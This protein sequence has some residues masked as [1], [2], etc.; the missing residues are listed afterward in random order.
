MPA[1]AQT[2]TPADAETQATDAPEAKSSSKKVCKNFKVTG[3]RLARQRVCATQA[4]WDRNAREAEEL[5]G[6]LTERP[7]R[8]PVEGAASS[9]F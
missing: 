6:T 4:E 1:V 9:P 7:A 2:S 8:G 3:S 5:G